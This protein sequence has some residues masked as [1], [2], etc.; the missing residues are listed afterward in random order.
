MTHW[1][2]LCQ[3]PLGTYPEQRFDEPAALQMIKDFQAELSSLSAAIT[4][5]NAELELPY[6]YLNPK[7]IE[8]SITN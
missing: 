1:F 6:N 3:V 7:E 2:G 4:K 8:N 5:R